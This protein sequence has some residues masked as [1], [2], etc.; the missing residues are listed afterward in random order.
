MSMRLFARGLLAVLLGVLTLVVHSAN[1]PPAEPRTP[2]EH[3]RGAEQTYLTFPEWYL[4]HSPAELADY[5]RAGRPPSA[6][7]FFGHIAQFWQGY[8]EVTRATH[9]APF[10]GGYHLMVSVIG[11]STTVEY[12]LK[13]CY[14]AT[15]GALAEATATNGPTPE[16]QLAARVAQDYVDF[17][18]VWPWY[19]YD[20]GK[21]LAELWQTA[22]WWGDDMLRKWERRFALTSEYG[23]KWAYAWLIKKA[24]QSIYDAPLPTTA[25]VLDRWPGSL[26]ELPELKRLRDVPGGVLVTVPRY[27]AFNRYA[28]A[29]AARA[30]HIDEVAGNRGPILV[31]LLLPRDA[32]PTEGTRLLFIQPVLTQ[33][34]TERRVLT[35]QVSS[36]AET[37]HAWAEQPGVKVEHVYDF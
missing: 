33:A 16:D 6:F 31:S 26:A 18:R 17:I 23:V 15:V 19:E 1:A 37:L 20:F 22:P 13:A 14:E 24:T 7:P 9:D 10:N 30:L 32:G 21:R 27:E 3:R 28:N 5:L 35:V 34:G 4:V 25:L 8:A 36:L 11:S 12:G 29:L 2:A